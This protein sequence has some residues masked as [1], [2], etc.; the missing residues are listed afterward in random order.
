MAERE[1]PKVF[2]LDRRM[3]LRLHEAVK[4]AVTKPELS[5]PLALERMLASEQALLKR[6]IERVRRL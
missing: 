1:Q 5:A 3:E 6:V 2:E 4:T